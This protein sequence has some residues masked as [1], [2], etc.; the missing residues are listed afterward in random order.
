MDDCVND[1]EKL[2]LRQE[3]KSYTTREKLYYLY[4][5]TIKFYFNKWELNFI[6]SNFN[7]V[8][9]K[10]YRMSDKVIIRI[11]IIFDKYVMSRVS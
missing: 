8:Y 10:Q 3:F 9:T 2:K 4:C 11:N 1:K 6:N 7:R 5:T